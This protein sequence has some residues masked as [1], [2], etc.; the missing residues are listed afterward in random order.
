MKKTLL[1][2]FFVYLTY[3]SF[4]QITITKNDMPKSGDTARYSTTTTLLNFTNTGANYRWDFSSLVINGQGIDTFKSVLLINPLLAFFFGFT[5]F[6]VPSTNK[7]PFTTLGLTSAYDF[8]KP[9]NSNLEI[10]GIAVT[11]AG[12]PFPTTY[13]T[14]DKVY[15]FPLTYGR[16][17]VSPYDVNIQIQGL[18]GIHQVGTRTNTVDGWGTVITPYDSF[19]CIRVKSVLTEVDSIDLTVVGLTIGIPLPTVSY[20]WLANG[21]KIP[22][23]EVDGIEVAGVFIPSSEKFRDAWRVVP[24]NFTLSVNFMANKNIVTTDDTVII[25]PTVTP[26][27]V[28]GTTYQYTVTPN[29]FNYISGTYSTSSTPQMKFNA[30][31]LYTVT[32]YST[33]PAGGTYPATATQTKPNYIYVTYPAGIQEVSGTNI[34]HVYPNPANDHISCLLNGDANSKATIELLDITGKMLYTVTTLQTGMVN[35]PTAHLPAGEY[36][37]R[38]AAANEASYL[39]K[40]TI[41]H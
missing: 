6:G 13:T 30:P 37:I 26:G 19:Q 2:S 15:Q 38:A 25:T 12:I 35:I 10:N 7:I 23:L 1:L 24:N 20:K 4:G 33:A 34:I 17:D 16:T 9:S 40:I 27:G 32:L 31:G 8:Y 39:Q 22:V 41:V 18:G 28:A 29:T 21:V 14:P 11:Y 36:L 3:I 5:D